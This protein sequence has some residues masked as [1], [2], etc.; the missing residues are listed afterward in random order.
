M[1]ANERPA[2][3]EAPGA[4]TPGE[5]LGNAE[6]GLTPARQSVDDPAKITVSLEG[7]PHYRVDE[8][9]S[10]IDELDSHVPGLSI[11]VSPELKLTDSHDDLVESSIHVRVKRQKS[12]IDRVGARPLVAK[13][14]KVLHQ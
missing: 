6:Q 9:R 3:R 8:V 5:S 10:L 13:L 4:P 11:T 7:S 2:Q 14:A 12:F 1:S